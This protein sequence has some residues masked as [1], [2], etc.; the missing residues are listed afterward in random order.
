MILMLGL[1]LAAWAPRRLLMPD[2]PPICTTLADCNARD[3]ARIAVIG[4]YRHYPDLPGFDYSAAPRAVRIDFDDGFGPF[5]DPFWSPRAIRPRS[6]IAQH[7]GQRVRV[8]GLYHKDMPRNPDDPPGRFRHGR[9]LYRGRGDRARAL[10]EACSAG[11]GPGVQPGMRVQHYENVRMEKVWGSYGYPLGRGGYPLGRGGHPLGRGGCPRVEGATRWVEAAAPWVEG[12]TRW[13]EAATRWVE[14]ATRW[15]EAATRWVEAA[16][17]WV[18]AATRWVEAAT[19]WVEAAT[20]W[21]EGA[22]R[23]VE[24]ATRWVEGATRWVEAA[25]RTSAWPSPAQCAKKQWLAAVS[26]IYMFLLCTKTPSAKN[27]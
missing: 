11:E 4:V 15:V 19:R 14:A 23:W 2:A 1:G 13:V 16:T 3:G 8:T 7:L 27:V 10:R 5:L 21:V 17:R 26:E 18:E 20:R 24:A 9:P 22:T 25:T 12:A 6:E